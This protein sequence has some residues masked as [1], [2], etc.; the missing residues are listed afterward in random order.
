M[1][2]LLFHPLTAIFITFISIIFLIS[3]YHS[4]LDIRKSTET[5]SVLDQENQKL[6]SEVSG[7]EKKLTMAESDFAKEKITR[8]ELLMQKPGEIIV[9]LPPLPNLDIQLQPETKN[10][11]PWEEWQKL[12]FN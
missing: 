8:D 6:A 5:I 3:L 1:Q 9:Q 7:L 10:L 2:K 12:L 11:T 4:N